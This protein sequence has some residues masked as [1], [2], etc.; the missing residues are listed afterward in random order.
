MELEADKQK[1][2]TGVTA[3]V[4]GSAS[5]A[6]RICQAAP[7]FMAAV[8]LAALWLPTFDSFLKVDHSPMP[9]ENRAPA[10][11]PVFPSE[12]KDLKAYLAG[13]ELYFNDHFG[14]RKL[15]IRTHG[16][17]QKKLLHEGSPDVLVGAAQWMYYVGNRELDDHMGLRVLK[18]EKL[19]EWQ[20]LLETRRDWLAKR[21]IKYLF[22]VPP[23]KESI[24]PEHLPEWANNPGAV[25]VLD[26]FL[27]H[28][29]AH[30]TVEILDLRP[31][32]KTAKQ[33]ARTYL[34]T[35][36]HWNYYGAFMGYRAIITALAGQLPGLEP[37]TIDRFEI[38]SA[39]S[40]GGDLAKMLAQEQ[41]T[42]ERDYV[43]LVPRPPLKAADEKT[44]ASI[45]EK[46]WA[47]EER[48]CFIENPGQKYRAVM[49]RDSFTTNLKP[50][51]GYN[52]QR[53][54][55]IWQRE[56]NEGVI[57]H[58]KPDVVIDEVLERYL[59]WPIP[60]H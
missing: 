58:E 51:L 46:K 40:N 44:D 37:L 34:Y 45:L 6:Q 15:F 33:T 49:F 43:T 31:A 5:V 52:F 12:L 22:V 60:T 29:K 14:F 47:E 4:A 38:H 20:K 3:A 53:I 2:T 30:S 48:P 16:F 10:V 50:F 35:D 41:S 23:N 8:F 27:A 1:P 9:I 36:T 11:R 28:M 55:F 19:A 13:W 7:L 25:T 17:F 39:P 26:Q 42:V 54:V 59:D 56:W 57:E 32:L 24:Y 18:P 21:G